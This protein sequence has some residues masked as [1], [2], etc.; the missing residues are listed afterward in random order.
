MSDDAAGAAPAD[1]APPDPAA[2]PA[3]APDRAAA[4]PAA[5]PAVSQPT[6]RLDHFLQRCGIAQTGGHAK[7]LV[8]SGE[9]LL[10]GQLETRRRK[11]LHPGDV[12]ECSGQTVTVDG[13][14]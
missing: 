5:D 12:V 11:K 8:Q 13:K 9:V 3:V 6:L 7:L 4:D 10:N 1:N 2:H 14:G